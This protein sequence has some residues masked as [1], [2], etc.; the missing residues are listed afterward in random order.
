MTAFPF[1]ECMYWVSIFTIYVIYPALYN[2]CCA[3]RKVKPTKPSK[4]HYEAKDQTQMSTK[5]QFDPKH[6]INGIDWNELN[7]L[8]C[9]DAESMKVNQIIN[10]KL[11][12]S[13]IQK[14]NFPQN[15]LD[16]IQQVKKQVKL[17]MEVHDAC[18]N[19]SGWLLQTDQ[20]NIKV[21]YR[22]EEGTPFHCIKTDFL[23]K[24]NVLEFI[25]VINEF[26]LVGELM[27]FMKIETEMI[28]EF[29]NSDKVVY[30]KTH[31]LWPMKHRDFVL[32]AGACNAADEMD[33][34]MVWAASPKDDKIE[35][36]PEVYIKSETECNTTRVDIMRMDICCK[37]IQFGIKGEKDLTR[38]IMLSLVDFKSY[39]PA[40]FINWITRTF[41]FQTIKFLRHRCEHLEGSK[42]EMR[43]KTK[44]IYKKWT[45]SMWEWQKN[46]LKN[47]GLK[48]GKSMPIQIKFPHIGYEYFES[49]DYLNLFPN[50]YP[51]WVQ[52]ELWGVD[53]VK[54]YNSEFL[55]SFKPADYDAKIPEMETMV[56]ALE[57][58][59]NW[60]NRE[61]KPLKQKNKTVKA[62]YMSIPN[63]SISA[64]KT[65]MSMP[66][67]VPIVTGIITNDNH[68][69]KYNKD[70]QKPKQVK[71]F[72][73]NCLMVYMVIVPP[74]PFIATRESVNVRFIYILPHC[75]VIFGEKSIEKSK[76]KGDGGGKYVRA[77]VTLHIWHVRPDYNSMNPHKNSLVTEYAH[78]NPAGSLPG[79]LIDQKVGDQAQTIMNLKTHI[80]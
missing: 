42:H 37:P 10:T 32:H 16:F 63:E 53:E 22:K 58:Y 74:V 64:V 2:C 36:H 17:A 4:S 26:D 47:G 21:E 5:I 13:D 54:E 40:K 23:C 25:A 69:S 73:Q 62:Y 30:M 14:Y 39:M 3:R 61:W 60:R 79:W 28:R 20:D 75:E 38:I 6:N 45:A 18:H 68:L 34:V 1:Y 44:P 7:T 35:S 77:N 11:D 46:K 65:V 57:L 43:I 41:Q 78:A 67:S 80:D 59:K 8:I 55:D 29:T 9:D 66:Y 71:N 50:N 49:R 24:C 52:S 48:S 27:S 12:M 33:E 56:E 15:I 70:F 31:M 19:D 72:S 51:K 76:Y